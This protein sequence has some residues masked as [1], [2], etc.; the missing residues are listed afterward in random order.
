MREM[1]LRPKC[2]SGTVE[3][4][5]FRVHDVSKVYRMG[6][7]E[8]RA[9]RSVSL[10]L[11]AREFVVL[12]GASGSG[13]S[14]LLNILGGLDHFPAQRSGDGYRLNAHIVTFSAAE[15]VKVAASALFPC[16]QSYCLFAIENGRARQRPVSVG[17][18]TS[19][20]AEVV[21]G[22]TVGTMVICYPPNDLRDGARVKAR[23]S[24]GR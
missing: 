1:V 24:S 3:A 7:V 5:V 6:E 10:D 21:G 11:Y 17:H 14:T 13:K 22:I 12:L 16:G 23:P 18:R 20:Y 2:D 8:I 9:L 15:V 4:A 19:D